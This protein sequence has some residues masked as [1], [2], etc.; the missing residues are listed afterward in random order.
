MNVPRE[1][2]PIVKPHNLGKPLKK[3]G[4]RGEK[5]NS[6]QNGAGGRERPD[7]S[8][9]GNRRRPPV[10]RGFFFSH[11]F[12]TRS[13]KGTYLRYS[14][15]TTK[16]GQYSCHCKSGENGNNE[17][18]LQAKSVRR[19]SSWNTRTNEEMTKRNDGKH[20]FIIVR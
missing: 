6:S 2:S 1:R 19:R 7:E 20:Y 4:K 13:R 8:P 12:R 16:F 5:L 11:T 14:L 15:Q 3:K 9:T 10:T 17:T 18:F